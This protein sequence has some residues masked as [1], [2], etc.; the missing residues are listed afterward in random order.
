[1]EEVSRRKIFSTN[2]HKI[3]THNLEANLGGHKFQLAVNQFADLTN[4]E[5]RQTLLGYRGSNK[6]IKPNATL[7]ASSLVSLPKSIDWRDSLVVEVKDQGQCGSCWAFSAIAS[8]EGQHAK[9]KGDLLSFSEQELVDCSGDEGNQGCNGGLMES[10]FEY[11]KKAGVELEDDY[12]YEAVDDTCRLDKKKIAEKVTGFVKIDS[13]SEDA[14]QNAVSEIG[15]ISVAIDAGSI[16]FQ[17]YSSGVYDQSGCGT[18]ESELNHGVTAVGYG[19]EGGD[20]YW[21]VKNSWGEGW[22]DAGYIKMSRNK[23]NQ[24]G[25]ATDASYPLL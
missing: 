3:A 14:L 12:P 7:I 9:L 19:S 10:A 5:Y 17:F 21:L 1:M 4:A 25:I 24:C 8:L 11:L 18:E 2:V 15:P 23:D 6:R 20:D 13:G 22:G 16:W